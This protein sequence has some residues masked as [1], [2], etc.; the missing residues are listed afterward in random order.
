MR[1]PSKSRSVDPDRHY[2]LPHPDLVC[3]PPSLMEDTRVNLSNYMSHWE[4]LGDDAGKLSR[5]LRD[6]EAS[7][8]CPDDLAQALSWAI[9]LYLQSG[10]QNRGGKGVGGR[11]DSA[12]VLTD[13]QIQRERTH[14][15]IT[16]VVKGDAAS[17]ISAGLVQYL[18]EIGYVGAADDVEK[19]GCVKVQAAID[20]AKSRKIGTVRDLA[21]YIRWSL[22]KGIFSEV[23][24]QPLWKYKHGRYGHVVQT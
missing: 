7:G 21:S 4:Q 6:L 17:Q 13:I 24:T 2:Q 11:E 23:P 12:A 19:Y 1:R 14:S 10:A 20:F 16:G 18:Q 22:A 8:G 9:S 3:V 5:N 15:S